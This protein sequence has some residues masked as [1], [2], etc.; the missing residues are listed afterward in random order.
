MFKFTRVPLFFRVMIPLWRRKGWDIN[1]DAIRDG[2]NYLVFQIREEWAIGGMF[3]YIT[4]FGVCFRA[5]H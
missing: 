3:S 4:R 1:N 2:R 5:V